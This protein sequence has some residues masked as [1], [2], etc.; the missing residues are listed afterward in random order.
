M[1]AAFRLAV[2][3]VLGAVLSACTGAPQEQVDAAPIIQPITSKLNGLGVVVT[4]IDCPP[5]IARAPGS[6]FTC[7]V[8]TDKGEPFSVVVT[9]RDEGG[10][11]KLAWETGKD[12][13]VPDRYIAEL[14]A[15]ARTISSD[16]VVSCPRAVVVAGGNGT[17]RCDVKDSTGQTGTLSV[18]VDDGVPVADQQ[19]W[20]IEQS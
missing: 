5:S 4:R 17:L 13:V 16:L 20:S 1:N 18:P 15:Y 9:Q 3:M 6:T 10:Q 2:P 7:T 14:T 8:V 19:Q 12:F 11:M